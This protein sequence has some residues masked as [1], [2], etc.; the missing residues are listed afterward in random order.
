MHIISTKCVT[1]GVLQVKMAA[2]ECAPIT[3]TRRME[4]EIPPHLSTVLVQLAH[5]MRAHL[6]NNACPDRNLRPH[7]LVAAAITTDIV[8]I[9]SHT[10]ATS[11][12]LQRR[13]KCS[14][15]VCLHNYYI[16]NV[17]SLKWNYHTGSCMEIGFHSTRGWLKNIYR[18][19]ARKPEGNTSRGRPNLCTYCAES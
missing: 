10:I 18:N 12:L 13:R 2:M 7:R 16:Y 17:C 8:P 11:H 9:V 14:T 6:R 3:R 19:I 5:P 15:K 4:T 1:L